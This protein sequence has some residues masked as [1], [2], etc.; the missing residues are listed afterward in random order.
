MSTEFESISRY[1]VVCLLSGLIQKVNQFARDYILIHYF[2]FIWSDDNFSIDLANFKQIVKIEKASPLKYCDT[3]SKIRKKCAKCLLF[4][5]ELFILIIGLRFTW[6]PIKLFPY[7]FQHFFLPFNLTADL[8]D[9][10]AYF[11]FLNPNLLFIATI[12]MC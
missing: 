1:I 3:V 5:I 10:F 8:V 2:A 12:L 4:W 6:T 7:F 9:L 11:I